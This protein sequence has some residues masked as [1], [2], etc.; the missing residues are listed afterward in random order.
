V[1]TRQCSVLP[2]SPL[3][4]ETEVTPIIY[5]AESADPDRRAALAAAGASVVVAGRDDVDL[6]AVV[7]DL[8]QRGLRRVDCE[9]GPRLL[10]SLIAAELVDELCLSVAP[11][12]TSG[13]SSRIAVGQLPAAPARLRL[14]SILH[15]DGLLMLRY[16]R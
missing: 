5:T 1:V 6:A 14:A 3:L 15:G 7:A 8:D 12:L 13:D 9:G 16:I 10:G 11:L 4:T 2:T